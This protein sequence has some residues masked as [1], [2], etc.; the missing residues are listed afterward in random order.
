MAYLSYLQITVSS[1]VLL[2]SDQTIPARA[3]FVELQAETQPVRY[4]MDDAT[5]PSASSGAVLKASGKPKLFSV[6]DFRRLKMIRGAGSD[7]KLNVHFYNPHRTNPT[8]A[9]PP[10]E[11]GNYVT[12][13]FEQVVFDD[14]GDLVTY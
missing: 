11:D 4:T 2:G 10:G 3:T 6:E 8:G 9:P 1:S 7:A 12:D 5:A 14:D 13:E